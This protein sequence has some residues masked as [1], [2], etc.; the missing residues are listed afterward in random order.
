MDTQCDRCGKELPLADPEEWLGVN[1]IDEP[2]FVGFH[3]VVG[4]SQIINKQGEF[5]GWDPDQEFDLCPECKEAFL[6]L[7]DNFY[8]PEGRKGLQHP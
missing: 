5:E 8:R 6:Q 2:W 4:G 1:Y 7:W 3:V